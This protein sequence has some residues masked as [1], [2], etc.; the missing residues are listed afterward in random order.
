MTNKIN[1]N[2]LYVGNLPPGV[3]KKEL[4][5]LFSQAGKVKRIFLK[6][7]PKTGKPKGFGFCELDSPSSATLAY[8]QLNN[9][10]LKGRKIKL[11]FA[12][13][14]SI[15]SQ[16]QQQQQQ[17]QQQQP[18]NFQQQQN[19][20][21][22]G[23]QPN[24]LQTP[25]T[26]SQNPLMPPPFQGPNQIPLQIPRPNNPNF[27]LGSNQ[28]RTGFPPMPGF[29]MPIFGRSVNPNLGI[30]PLPQTTHLP[31]IPPPMVVGGIVNQPPNP[32]G[33]SFQILK[34]S[35]VDERKN[36]Q[37]KTQINT[38]QKE[39]DNQAKQG[40]PENLDIESIVSRLSSM[41]IQHVYQAIK[42]LKESDQDE[43]YNLLIKYPKLAQA[44]LQIQIIFGMVRGINLEDLTMQK[45]KN[46]NKKKNINYLND[47]L[48]HIFPLEININENGNN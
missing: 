9:Y 4:A 30:F 7:D 24:I 45:Q 33:T 35:H 48:N 26:L 16:Q 18:I 13:R 43:I 20:Q 25:N 31:N 28:Q 5:S 3:T 47:L 21:M 39:S 6:T 32:M 36:E 46:L 14:N 15:N 44:V 27:F 19:H 23:I 11:D 22:K 34:S 38:N 37:Q 8:Q 12:E 41:S 17:K 10:T 40:E 2:V 29:G 1:S 42:E